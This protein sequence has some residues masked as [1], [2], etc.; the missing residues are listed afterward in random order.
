MSGIFRS[1]LSTDNIFLT[2]L[3]PLSCAGLPLLVVGIAA[4]IDISSYGTE[5]YCW[6]AVE[7]NF[8]WAFVAPV[9]V[10]IIVNTMFLS[11]AV[12]IMCRHSTMQTNQKEK[13]NKEKITSWVRG[14]LVLLCLLGVTWAF[15]LL[16][17]T[18]SLLVF[19]YIFTI[20]NAFQGV[21]IFVFHCFM[22]E[23]VVKEYRRYIRN[24]TW[25]PECIRDRYG[26]TFF[27]G[28]N[29]HRSSSSSGKRRIWSQ[30]E[31]RL[32]N[33]TGS[34]SVDQGHRKLST[35][36]N[37][38]NSGEYGPVKFT[39]V[40]KDGNP[41][42]SDE[43]IGLEMEDGHMEMAQAANNSD[44]QQSTPTPIPRR[45]HSFSD[46][47]ASPN[48][49]RP[50]LQSPTEPPSYKQP[51]PPPAQQQ[52]KSG[53]FRSL[54]DLLSADSDDSGQHPNTTKKSSLPDLPR[55]PKVLKKRVA[56]VNSD[57]QKVGQWSPLEEYRP[58]EED[59]VDSNA[60]VE[61]LGISNLSPRRETLI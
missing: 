29:Q 49:I 42:L 51:P 55:S 47:P 22:N 32:S 28:S 36:S 13:T 60:G 6:L 24:S 56:R 16:Y 38:R 52:P 11:M 39:P 33:T 21:F 59:A 10:I 2:Y 53:T 12:F 26:S 40:N 20:A 3:D 8:I 35:S 50:L 61:F 19:A 41:R 37:G 25:M 31:K 17:V 9:V 44:S 46:S 15:G 57:S 5:E 23:K 45:N 7:N 4:A 14:G 27:T 58:D 48:E 43:G 1:T 18:E 34:C 54:P 30:E